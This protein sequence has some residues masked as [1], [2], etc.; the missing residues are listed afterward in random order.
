MSPSSGSPVSSIG[1]REL[2]RAAL[3]VFGATLPRGLR[4][5]GD[6]LD[7]FLGARSSEALVRVG[8]RCR[9]AG[10]PADAAA[11]LAGFSGAGEDELS[12]FLTRAVHEDFAADRVR[13]I[14]P[15]L[16]SESECRLLALL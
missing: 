4:G 3:V 11:L 7:D 14:G 10:V 16:L 2:L 13:A 12:A 1:R 8:E 9:A 5:G 15:W 6:D